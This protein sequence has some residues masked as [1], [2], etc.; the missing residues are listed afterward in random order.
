MEGG[1]RWRLDR[2]RGGFGVECF[3]RRNPSCTLRGM[4]RWF[5]FV[6]DLS[7]SLPTL[8]LVVITSYMASADQRV[9]YSVCISRCARPGGCRDALMQLALG[10]GRRRL[11]VWT[12]AGR[13]ENSDES[14][15]V[16][17]ASKQASKPS[18]R[19]ESLSPGRRR[20]QEAKSSSH[21]QPTCG[22]SLTRRRPCDL[23][24]PKA[25]SVVVCLFAFAF[26]CSVP[27]E[28]LSSL[29]P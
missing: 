7:I 4:H 10:A 24:V 26:V 8:P 21:T 18:S 19:R 6:F 28:L 14:G 20:K 29:T 2:G 11:R 15:Q 17:Q 27:V 1:K 22:I 9:A 12:A 5:C 3:G 16:K 25:G 23:H 13:I